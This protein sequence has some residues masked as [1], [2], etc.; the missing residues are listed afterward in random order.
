MVHRSPVLETKQQGISKKEI[1]RTAHTTSSKIRSH[2]GSRPKNENIAFP[3]DRGR[4]QAKEGGGGICRN[5]VQ[6]VAQRRPKLTRPQLPVLARTV[7]DV[8]HSVHEKAAVHADQ[9]ASTQEHGERL[10]IFSFDSIHILPV[11][12]G[13]SRTQSRHKNSVRPTYLPF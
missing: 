8:D 7:C 2:A 11:G 1:R 3:A 5:A 4:K 10:F 12:D 9:R 13:V 6:R